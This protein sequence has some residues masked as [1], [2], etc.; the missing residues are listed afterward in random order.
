M[1]RRDLG[2]AVT[3]DGFRFYLQPDGT[4]TDGDMT[5]TGRDALEREGARFIV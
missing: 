2:V 3:P 5:W 4:W 1:M